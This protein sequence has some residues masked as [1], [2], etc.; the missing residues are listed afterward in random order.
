MIAISFVSF[1][2][3]QSV[4]INTTSCHSILALSR[5][6]ATDSYQSRMR[7]IQTFNYCTKEVQKT[8][9][10]LI[11]Y[12]H[13]EFDVE[14]ENIVHILIDYKHQ[15]EKLDICYIRPM[16]CA[17]YQSRFVD[18]F[19]MAL[20][21]NKPCIYKGSWDSQMGYWATGHDIRFSYALYHDDKIRIRWTL[22]EKLF[23]KLQDV[24]DRDGKR[25][26]YSNHEHRN[27]RD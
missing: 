15:M 20:E 14:E 12:L 13:D 19:K 25:L 3:S 6:A 1:I 16:T 8:N 27:Y 7:S 11:N 4:F 23:Y 17:L 24:R 5:H 26:R 10:F 2:S 21:Q 18:D 9:Q 22:G